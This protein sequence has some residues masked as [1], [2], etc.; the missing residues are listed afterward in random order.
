MTYILNGKIGAYT[1]ASQS[2]FTS[3]IYD[4]V[5]DYQVMNDDIFII[6][7]SLVTN[8][9]VS[10]SRPDSNTE[11]DID[12]KITEITTS[13]D[14]IMAG[15]NAGK[16]IGFLIDWE[17]S[18]AFPDVEYSLAYTKLKSLYDYAHTKSILFGITVQPGD[19]SLVHAGIDLQDAVDYLDFFMPQEYVQ[20]FGNTYTV[21]YR[22]NRLAADFL[23]FQE[24]K[25]AGVVLICLANLKASADPFEYLTCYQL[26]DYYKDVF[27]NDLADGFA[28][29]NTKPLHKDYIAAL[30]RIKLGVIDYSYTNKWMNYY[31][32]AWTGTP[33]DN[34][35][36]AKQMG[37]DYICITGNSNN[38]QGY[39][40]AATDNGYTSENPLM[41]YF[42]NPEQASY[43]YSTSPSVPTISQ[44]T[45]SPNLIDIDHTY[46]APQIAWYEARAVWKDN[47]KTWPDNLATGFWANKVN[48]TFRRFAIQWD[49]QQ[50]SVRAELKSKIEQLIILHETTNFKFAGIMWDLPGFEGDFHSQTNA[51]NLITDQ[52]ANGSNSGYLHGT[53]TH[54]YSTFQDGMAQ[55][56]KELFSYLRGLY[57]R[58]KWITDPS[59]PYATFTQSP[60]RKE[61]LYQASLRSD[62]ADLIPDA[63]LQENGK[64]TETISGVQS[65]Y[66]FADDTRIFNVDKMPITPDMVGS[67]QRNS[68]DETIGRTIAGKAGA[69]GSWYNWFG[70]FTLNDRISYTDI[71]QLPAWLKLI[72]CIPGWDNLRQIPFVARVWD[73]FVYQSTYSYISSNIIYSRHPKTDKIFVVYLTTNGILTIGEN[74]QIFSIQKTDEYMVESEN[75]YSDFIITGNQLK[76]KNGIN[77]NKCYIITTQQLIS[78][79]PSVTTDTIT[80]ISSRT[81]ILNGIVN[82]NGY[83]TQAWFQYDTTQILS[84]STPAIDLSGSSNKS[85]SSEIQ[86]LLPGT[87]YFVRTV[88][89]NI[90]GIV[91]GDIVSFTTVQENIVPVGSVTINSGLPYTNTRNATLNLSASDNIGITG[92]FVSSSPTTPDINNTSWIDIS[93]TIVLVKNITYTLSSVN[94]TKTVYVWYRDAIGNISIVSSDTIILD[95]QAPDITI[96]TPTASASYIV[97]TNTITLGGTSSDNYSGISKVTWTNNRGGSGEATGTINWNIYNIALYSG[98]NIITVTATDGAGNI[99]TDI[100]TITRGIAPVISTQDTTNIAT[101]SATIN[102]MVNAGFIATTAW[103]EYGITSG[104]YPNTTTPQNITGNIDTAISD[105]LSGLIQNTTYYYR[106]VANNAA[107]L[108]NGSELSFRTLDSTVPVGTISIN[109]NDTYSISNTVTLS[110]SASDTVGV[111]GYFVSENS[112]PPLITDDGWVS[113]TPITNY[114]ANIQ[115]V[116]SFGD[117]TK[118]V[119]VWYRDADENISITSI[120]SIIVDTT[121]PELTITLPTSFPYT[122]QNDKIDISGTS[123]DTNGIS[124]ITLSSDR[125]WSGTAIG[126]TSWEMLQLSL[127]E[128]LNNITITARDNAGL[129]TSLLITIFYEK[130]IE[131]PI[132]DVWTLRRKRVRYMD[133]I[134]NNLIIKQGSTFPQTFQLKQITGQPVD[135]TGYNIRGQIRK[136]ALSRTKIFDFAATITNALN[137]I[138]DISLTSEQTI[139]IPIGKYSYDIE[140]YTNGGF[141]ER[142]IEGSVLV[143]P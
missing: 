4:P 108:V 100:I 116:L 106:I 50:A 107:G 17:F 63:L 122:T 14:S 6:N 48:G 22:K 114:S 54:D 110:L 82:P 39:K 66:L 125:G 65:A 70:Q 120:D 37:Y 101:E 76:I 30:T 92:Y 113:I 93:S 67:H 40:D 3:Y 138:I 129:E 12:A 74:E 86:T 57:P 112:T 29:W 133:A 94:G 105:N 43:I 143:T 35:K 136:T 99:A 137:G 41:F 90:Y 71:T 115:K 62:R 59:Y 78:N 49:Y 123:S 27:T 102:G 141:V 1:I 83:V 45:W 142:I 96:D 97:T 140:I 119:Y 88:G 55:Y 19:S 56:Y 117:G 109:S 46:T 24:L 10:F 53:I 38:I 69:V 134:Y 126:T 5:F 13:I 11:V 64:I 118:T 77:T 124:N 28:V 139:S 9:I 61:Y 25:N 51:N 32:V 128:G 95:E 89:Q 60:A 23:K 7:A 81:A 80:D 121:P 72:R 68:H 84:K 20:N 8:A 34:V 104:V 75:G 135:L 98:N 16:V 52:T 31:G 73:G 42:I 131:L 15:A 44:I 58:C 91:Y 21:E 47:T 2:P 36:Y 79:P 130:Q 87:K 103:F 33:A 111:T 18:G 26:Y 132:I 127:A 85:I